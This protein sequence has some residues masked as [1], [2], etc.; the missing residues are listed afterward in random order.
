M[1]WIFPPLKTDNT[2][3]QQLKAVKSELKEFEEE[4]DLEKKAIELFDLV[5][6][7]ETLTR[8][9]FKKTNISP[10]YVITQV[11]EK[12]TRRNYY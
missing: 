5:H 3:E 8:I 1:K 10:D 7:V 4:M 2:V 6:S 9:F 11:V 12:N